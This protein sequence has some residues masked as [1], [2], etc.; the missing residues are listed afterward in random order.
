MVGAVP[1][2]ENGGKRITNNYFE[3]TNSGTDS[4]SPDK[5]A[6]RLQ[7]MAAQRERERERERESTR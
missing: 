4:H 1:G 6:P 2:V 3:Q 7:V 5:Q